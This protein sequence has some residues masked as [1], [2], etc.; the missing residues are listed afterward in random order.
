LQ[1]I[2][3]RTLEARRKELVACD[4]LIEKHVRDFQVWLNR[5]A[6]VTVLPAGTQGP[7]T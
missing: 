6:E 7:R 2:A 4:G 3:D 1:A 5:A